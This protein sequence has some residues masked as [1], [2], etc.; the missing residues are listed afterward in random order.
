M[1]E[2]NVYTTTLSQNVNKP[3]VTMRMTRKTFDDITDK[4]ISKFKAVVTGKISISGSLTALKAFDNKVVAKYF[5][6]ETLSPLK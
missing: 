4:N 1:K 3:D 2:S 6:K 5:D